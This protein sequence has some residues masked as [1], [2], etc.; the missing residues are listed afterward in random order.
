MVIG[1]TDARGFPD[2]KSKL[3]GTLEGHIFTLDI[4]SIKSVLT[5]YSVLKQ[6]I[7]S[8]FG[9]ERFTFSFTLKDSPDHFINVSSW[10]S[11]EYING[12]C[13]SFRTGDCGKSVH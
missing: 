2:K 4:I 3:I 8:D 6:H 11:E 13:G 9:S 5:V 10:G 7:L 12:L 1:K